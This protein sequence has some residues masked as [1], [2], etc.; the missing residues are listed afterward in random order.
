MPKKARKGPKPGTLYKDVARTSVG[1][2]IAAARRRKGMTQERL[3]HSTGL[4]KTT[5]SYYER[6]AV[7]IPLESLQRIARALNVSVDYL[8]NTKGNQAD[9][10][11][12]KALLIRLERAKS[13]PPEKQKLIVDL[14][15]TLS[16]S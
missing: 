12:S 7:A 9:L 11:A 16:S 14:I 5:I 1:I 4:D 2:N 15:D 8:M 3:A 6:K 13:L 10:T